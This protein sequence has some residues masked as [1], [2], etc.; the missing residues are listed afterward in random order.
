M[1][2]TQKQ[3][4][5]DEQ[6]RNIAETLE[7]LH[8]KVET[9]AESESILD[10]P[11]GTGDYDDG[12]PNESLDQFEEEDIASLVAGVKAFNTGTLIPAAALLRKIAVQKPF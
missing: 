10:P 3:K 7:Q 8:I 6:L 5:V 11:I 2:K 12:R 4:F 9:L 1:A